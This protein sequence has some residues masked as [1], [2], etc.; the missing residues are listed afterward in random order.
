MA[1]VFALDFSKLIYQQLTLQT[2]PE[3]LPCLRP[4]VLKLECT[5]ESSRKLVGKADSQ[6]PPQ[7][8]GSTKVLGAAQ[9]S[10]FPISHRCSSFKT[11]L[12]GPILKRLMGLKK[13]CG[14]T[15]VMLPVEFSGL[16]PRISQI[17]GCT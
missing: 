13:D 10:A 2:F 9:E 5:E 4:E 6:A 8:L 16:V 7:E 14:K 11:L 3:Y 17:K 15:P 12:V 1:L